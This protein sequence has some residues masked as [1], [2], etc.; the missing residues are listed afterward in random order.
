MLQIE[1]PWC[2]PRDEQEFSYG[3]EAHI[4]RPAEPDRVSD[5]AWADYLFFRSN[6]RGLQSELWCHRHGCRR[7]FNVMRDT[8]TYRIHTVY[9]MGESPPEIT[10]RGAP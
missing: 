9:R 1:C 3:G 2:G 8:V 10:S 7:W 5:R 6:T 4:R